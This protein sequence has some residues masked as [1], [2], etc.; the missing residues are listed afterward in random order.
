MLPDEGFGATLDG[1]GGIYSKGLAVDMEA[2]SCAARFWRRRKR[3]APNRAK[4]MRAM[5]PI[6]APTIGPT[7][8]ELFAVEVAETELPVEVDVASDDADV[9]VEESVPFWIM[10]SVNVRG[11]ELLP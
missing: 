10:R 1:C 3:K 8:V 7:G 5:P 4:R 9:D 2:F 6:T 11:V